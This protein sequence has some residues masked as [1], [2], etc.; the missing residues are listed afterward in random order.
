MTSRRTCSVVLFALSV[1]VLALFA[2]SNHPWP[3]IKPLAKS[4]DFPAVDQASVDFYLNDAQGN[5]VYW[6]GCHS[7]DFSG[8]SGDPFH[9]D[10]WDYYGAFDCHLHSLTD[11]NG[12][13]LLSY[14]AVDPRENFSRALTVPKQLQGR[15]AEYPEWGRLRH[16]RVR[17]MLITLEYRDPRFVQKPRESDRPSAG[18]PLQSFRFDVR[19]EQDKSALSAF[20]EPPPY[21][22]PLRTQ[23]GSTKN[24][25]DDCAQIIFRGTHGDRQMVQ[26]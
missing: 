8:R 10:K 9:D 14:D 26:P 22:Y 18:L 11:K 12:F 2:S 15:C 19:V 21:E 20:A 24:I 4:F 6:F 3:E 25:S 17:G 5:S 7:A 1:G 23:P 13:N 16:I